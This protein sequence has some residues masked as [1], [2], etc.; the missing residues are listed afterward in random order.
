[1]DYLLA[2]LA[3]YDTRA[4]VGHTPPTPRTPPT[5]LTPPTPPTPR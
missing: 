4:A 1:V 3:R 5:P 2:R